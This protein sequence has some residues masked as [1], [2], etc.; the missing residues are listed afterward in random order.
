[1]PSPPEPK[2]GEKASDYVGRCMEAISDCGDPQDQKLA[3]CYS[4]F[5]ETKKAA[6]VSTALRLFK[7]LILRRLK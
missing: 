4:K 2:G 3:A 6:F 7:S 1:M 5:R